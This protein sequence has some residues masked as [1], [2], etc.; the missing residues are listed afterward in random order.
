M[1]IKQEPIPSAEEFV[2]HSNFLYNIIPEEDLVSNKSL[3]E[4]KL[5]EFVHLHLKQ[6]RY[7]YDQYQFFIN[8]YRNGS[9]SIS[10]VREAHDRFLKLL[11]I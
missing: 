2:N 11:E 7:E 6:I 9:A 8:G 10:E 3:L 5:T 1:R 4:E